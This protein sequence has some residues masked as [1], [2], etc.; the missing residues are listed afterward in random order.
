MKYI[1]CSIYV[2]AL[3]LRWKYA[4]KQIGADLQVRIENK[5]ECAIMNEWRG[6]WQLRKGRIKNPI[7][8]H[9]YVIYDLKK[10]SLI[11]L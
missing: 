3:L 1:W 10:P 11:Y 4:S 2:N 7:H 6:N 9:I 5:N 8:I